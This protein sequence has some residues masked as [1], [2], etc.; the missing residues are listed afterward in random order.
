MK[1]PFSD[2]FADMA[3]LER[4]WM[5]VM[6][7]DCLFAKLSRRLLVAFHYGYVMIGFIRGRAFVDEAGLFA[8][9]IRFISTSG[10]NTFRLLVIFGLGASCS[11]S[12]KLTSVFC[13]LNLECCCTVFLVMN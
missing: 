1:K 12:R 7:F 8:M 9:G 4:Y 6:P 2:R 13:N 3:V 11:K 10:V 5:A